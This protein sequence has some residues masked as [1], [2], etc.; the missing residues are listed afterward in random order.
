MVAIV[1]L[2]NMGFFSFGLSGNMFCRLP[3]GF[4]CKEPH[5]DPN[6]IAFTIQNQ[7]LSPIKLQ[8]VSI[9]SGDCSQKVGLDDKSLD[10]R[11]EYRIEFVCAKFPR[12]VESEVAIEYMNPYTGLTFKETG[13]IRFT[14]RSFFG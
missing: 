5:A 2:F 7:K 9:L 6:V 4:M 1:L 13:Q 12:I 10:T 8:S 3:V 14:T 11:D